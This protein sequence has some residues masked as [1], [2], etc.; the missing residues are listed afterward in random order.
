MNNL[1]N[2]FLQYVQFETTSNPNCVQSPSSEG[3]SKFAEFLSQELQ[4]IGLQDVQ[5]SE[6]GYLT[7]LLPS[8]IV[9]STPVIG[10]ISHLDT[11]PDFSAKDVNAQIINNYNGEKISLG[12]DGTLFLSPDI[13]PELNSLKGRTLVTTNGNSL[14]GA[15]DKAGITAIVSAMEF[16][17]HHPEI[18]HGAIR[19]GFTPD[20]E[21][22]RGADFFDV[23]SFGADWA[24]TIDGGAIGELEFENF[25]AAYAKVHIS[26][27]SVHPGYAFN[28]MVNASLI[29]SEFI[30]IL[31]SNETPS[32]TVDYEGF[33]H[34]TSIAGDVSNANLEF[35]IRDH[36]SKI[37]AQRKNRFLEIERFLNEKYGEN[38]VNVEVK[39]QYFNM[40]EKIEPVIHIVDLAKKAMEKA[41]V[42]PLIRPIRGG[43]DGARLSYMGLPCPNI[44]TGGYNFHGPYEFL[45][46]E[47]LQKSVE[48][49]I[50]ICALASAKKD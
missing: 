32:T 23:D 8:N 40:K 34:L 46:L 25:N 7:A 12:T 26:G 28:K 49:I 19:I 5:I 3:Q 35:I 15:D 43:T 37:F 33:Y 21:I 17:V 13:F 30:Q 11:S 16:L 2:R 44:F 41:G 47:Y 29:A 9:H 39:D 36:D 14:L 42:K 48:T 27:K 50:N 4:S 10:F 38:T 18:P 45:V 20:E 1:L 31:P 6:K 24:Y 22:G